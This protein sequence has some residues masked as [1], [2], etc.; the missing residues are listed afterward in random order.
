MKHP[1][2]S[3]ILPVYNGE[4]YIRQS[5]ESIL[6]QTYQDFELLVIDDGSTDGTAGIVKAYENRLRYIRQPNSGASHAR[7]QG[8]RLSQGKH[9][10][11]Q[12]ADDLWEPEKLAIQ[13]NFLDRHP[14]VG[15]VHCDCEIIDE[16]GHTIFRSK[17]S[18][19]EEGYWRLFQQGHAVGMYSVMLRREL[20]DKTGLFDEEF[21]KAGLEDVDF[22]ARLGKI[23][24]FHCLPTVLVKHRFHRYSTCKMSE[25]TLLPLEHRAL[26]L[27]K[28]LARFGDDPERR[29]FLE[30][31]V[32]SYKSDLG[33][34]LLKQGRVADGRKEL[35]DSILMNLKGPR[36]FGK[37]GRSILRLIRS[38]R[39]WHKH[40]VET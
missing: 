40:K 33:K 29:K 25:N 7:N 21:P 12:D 3:V 16:E 2:V 20:L 34:F 15:L 1:C 23:T 32:V 11:F 38:A 37:L 24:L 39:L 5:I 35:W 31:E 4:R 18:E 30:G 9:V 6:A 10:A 13:V 28:M 27:K 19:R 36:D 14:D 17:H 26:M 8:I 22:W